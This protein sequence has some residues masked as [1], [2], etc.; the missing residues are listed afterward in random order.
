MKRKLFLIIIVFSMVNLFSE[1]YISF[2]Y[3]EKYGYLNDFLEVVINPIYD[4]A[5]EFGNDGYAI[6]FE[7]D[8][9]YSLIDKKGQKNE[10]LSNCYRLKRIFDNVY[11]N[12]WENYIYNVKKKEFYPFQSPKIAQFCKEKYLCPVEFYD[13]N[14]NQFFCYLDE[15]GK[16][17][18][19]KG[20]WRNCYPL[21][22]NVSVAIDYNYQICL[23]NAAGNVIADGI[24][25]SAYNFSEGLLA[26]KTK[27]KKGFADT[28]GNFVFECELYEDPEENYIPSLD[29][30]FSEGVVVIQTSEN[31]YQIR[32]KTGK[33]LMNQR[34]FAVCGRMSCGKILCKESKN[35][36]Y[37]YINQYGDYVIAPCFDEAQ[38]FYNDFAIVVYKGKD[39]MLSADGNLY[40]IEDLL[41]GK[42]LPLKIAD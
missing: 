14:G 34:K 25:D 20:K 38:P 30:Y 17:T 24:Q 27:T 33:V 29:Y 3:Q 42:K 10:K 31:F 16:T 36:K 21:V 35:S 39:A 1:N 7:E 8:N 2:K 23:L 19:I 13:K 6:V 32:D 37:G 18:L 40:F 28:N 11:Y 12:N 26:V 4:E 5:E 15:D 22:E 41:E 9:E